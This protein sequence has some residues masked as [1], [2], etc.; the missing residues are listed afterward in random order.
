M[1][2]AGKLRIPSWLSRDWTVHDLRRILCHV[3]SGLACIPVSSWLEISRRTLT[4]RETAHDWPEKSEMTTAPATETLE[5]CVPITFHSRERSSHNHG[6]TK[7]LGVCRPD[8]GVWL[9]AEARRGT[10]QNRPKS[11][12]HEPKPRV[13]PTG[14]RLGSDAAG[15]G[16][17]QLWYANKQRERGRSPRRLVAATAGSG[18]GMH[19][20]AVCVTML[21]VC[22]T[23]CARCP[24]PARRLDIIFRNTICRPRLLFF[25]ELFFFRDRA[26]WSMDGCQ[27]SERDVQCRLGRRP[28][29]YL[30][31]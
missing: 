19:A 12:N 17:V 4:K 15:G 30:E 20:L 27:P 3:S 6:P 2:V 25:C 9:I 29:A 23:V 26:P 31:S 24:G 7:K 28:S 13:K 11:S 8:R 14:R 1:N 18:Q 5:K 21:H 16:R 10:A 22:V